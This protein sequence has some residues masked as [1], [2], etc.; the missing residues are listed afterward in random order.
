V[1]AAFG[2]VNEI[3]LAKAEAQAEV[4]MS[5]AE[6]LFLVEQVYRSAWASEMTKELGGR[7]MSEAIGQALE[8]AESGSADAQLPAEARK[9]MEEMRRAVDQAAQSPQLQVPPANIEL[10]R[11]HEPEIKKY[12]MSGLDWLGL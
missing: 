10:F 5:D 6:Y 3:R 1:T 8:Q 11:R 4:R 12:A 9:A 7:S 2:L